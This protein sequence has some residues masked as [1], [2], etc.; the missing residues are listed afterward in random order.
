MDSD[1]SNAH[2]V[3]PPVGEN[4]NFPLDQRFMAWGPTGRDIAFVFNDALYLLSLDSNEAQRVTQDDAIVSHPTW[5][6]Y[7][8]SDSDVLPASDVEELPTPLP[9]PVDTLLPRD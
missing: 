8:Q 7:G 2:Q 6:P 5:A 3:Y 1:G 4:S 9:T